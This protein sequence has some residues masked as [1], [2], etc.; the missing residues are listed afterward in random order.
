[1][2]R[3]E[4]NIKLT[5]DKPRKMKNVINL[6]ENIH[7]KDIKHLIVVGVLSTISR[8]PCLFG[9]FVF[10]DRPAILN[11]QDVNSDDSIWNLLFVHDFWGGN[12]TAKSSHKSFR[13]VLHVQSVISMLYCCFVLK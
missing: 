13:P 6:P 8:I 2:K 12:L 3:T 9:D 1:M 7:R 5:D 10:D 11:N 4:E